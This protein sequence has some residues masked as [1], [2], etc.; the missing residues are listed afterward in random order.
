MPDRWYWKVRLKSAWP[1]RAQCLPRDSCFLLIPSS[2]DPQAALVT[3]KTP[4]TCATCRPAA[5]LTPSSPANDFALLLRCCSAPWRSSRSSLCASCCVCC[6][7]RS[8]AWHQR[9]GRGQPGRWKFPCRQ[10]W[11]ALD[12][13]RSCSETSPGPQSWAGKASHRYL[14]QNTGNK[15]FGAV[16][17]LNESPK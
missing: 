15:M 17:R 11:A 13:W 5:P 1:P 7:W 9:A 16:K 3:I 4:A 6:I 8:L 12:G 14:G 10:D 2:W